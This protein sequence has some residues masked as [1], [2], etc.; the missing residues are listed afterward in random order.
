MPFVRKEGGRGKNPLESSPR[1]NPSPK[2]EAPSKSV[3]IPTKANVPPSNLSD[4]CLTIYGEKGVG[5]TSLAAQF[6]KSV[7][8]LCEPRRRNLKIVQWPEAGSPRPT[9]TE[10]KEWLRL[11]VSKNVSVNIDTVDEVYFLCLQHW[12][13]IYGGDI[14]NPSDTE[15]P[16]GNFWVDV[17]D[18]FSRTFNELLYS[19]VGVIFLSHAKERD[20]ESAEEASK[21]LA[22]TCMPSCLKY[23][24]SVSDFAFY[25]GYKGASR[26]IFL[27]GEE[28]LWSS[29]GVDDHFLSPKGDPLRVIRAGDI[30]PQDTY[31]RLLDAYAN[32]VYDMD[33]EAELA[34]KA[35]V[36]AGKKFRK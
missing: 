33:Q 15:S 36:E 31:R 22:P 29:C 4:Y 25:Y 20:S 21:M 6:P 2:A 17:R 7:T 26:A 13:A 12:A 10:V 11:A 5:K 3:Y 24:K 35:K 9:W 27:R 1:K 14:D 23:V 8:L 32:K 28:R 30:S 16:Y 18:D 19:D 34:A